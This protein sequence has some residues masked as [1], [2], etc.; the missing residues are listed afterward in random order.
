M[1]VGQSDAIRRKPAP[2]GPLM[3]AG[4]FGVK[5][6]ECMYVGDTSTDMK[7]GK[8]AGMFTVG[9]LWGFRDRE[10]LNENGADIVAEAPTAL[11]KICEEHGND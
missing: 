4:K 6:E 2:D 3:V 9:A 5:P 7:T 10:E 1:V 8:A 11:V